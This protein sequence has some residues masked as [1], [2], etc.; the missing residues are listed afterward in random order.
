MYFHKHLLL[1]NT[2]SIFFAEVTSTD[3][4]FVILADPT[5]SMLRTEPIFNWIQIWM[6]WLENLVICY[7]QILCPP[8]LGPLKRT[9]QVLSKQQ[10]VWFLNIAL[11]IVN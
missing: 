8:L 10:I 5:T 1:W 3:Q 9:N 7:K 6:V 11:G 4:L 2:Y